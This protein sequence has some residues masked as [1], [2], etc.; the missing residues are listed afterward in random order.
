[1]HLVQ[2][3]MSSRGFSLLIRA[4]YTKMFILTSRFRKWLLRFFSKSLKVNVK[5]QRSNVNSIKL[6]VHVYSGHFSNNDDALPFI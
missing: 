4:L 1:M 6:T 5:C 3:L 2:L